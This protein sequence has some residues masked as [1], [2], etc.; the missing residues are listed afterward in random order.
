MCSRLAA[1]VV[2]VHSTVAQNVDECL[3]AANKYRGMAGASPIGLCPDDAQRQ[4]TEM[5]AYDEV[6]GPHAYLAAYG[7]YGFCGPDTAECQTVYGMCSAAGQG[8]SFGNSYDEALNEFYILGPGEGHYEGMVSEDDTCVACGYHGTYYTFNWCN[9]DPIDPTVT[10]AP[11]PAPTPTGGAVSPEAVVTLFEADG[12]GVRVVN[13][14][15][16]VPNFNNDR[17]GALGFDVCAGAAFDSGAPLW[18]AEAGSAVG[19]IEVR[20]AWRVRLS[21]DCGLTYD[22]D[23]RNITV[24]REYTAAD[25]AA[26]FAQLAYVELS[27]SPVIALYEAGGGGGQRVVNSS[28]FAANA[29]SGRGGALAFDTCAGATFDDGTAMWDAAGGSNVGELE[30]LGEWRVKLSEDCGLTF[31]TD[32]MSVSREYSAADGRTS[33]FQLN[34]LEL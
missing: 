13:T 24:S 12:A 31:D 30:V 22:D 34:Y 19:R 15:E 14:S 1:L 18:T 9:R 8:E 28:A 16:L 26:S 4:A 20:G 3:T 27:D 6:N 33:F 25:G 21:T 23:A 5:A 32:G 11:T 10:P 7:W 2:L 29:N 17:G